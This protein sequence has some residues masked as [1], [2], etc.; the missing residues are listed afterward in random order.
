MVFL[1]RCNPLAI[2]VLSL[3]AIIYGNTAGSSWGRHSY[4]LTTFDP[5][6]NLD[7][8][9][10]A[11]RAS[12]LGVPIVALCLSADPNQQQCI[13]DSAILTSECQHDIPNTGGIYISIPLRFL[14]T[15]PLVIDDGTPRIVP[16]SSTLCLVHTGV[17][18]DGRALS[19]IA[20]KLVLDHKY[21]YGE[22]MGVQDLLSGL[23]SKMQEMTMKGGSRPYGCALLVCCLDESGRNAM[24][25][26]DPSGAVVL[27]SSSR[28]QVSDS[29]V[30]LRRSV[31]LMGNWESVK[32]K[33]ELIEQHL[34]K[35]VI[36]N[37]EQIQQLLMDAARQTFIDTSDDENA[38]KE[39]PILLAS[40]TRQ[41][42][43]SI[44]RIT[45]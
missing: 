35:Q 5:S 13:E 40:F 2:I 18:A 24:Y 42:G 31:T 9:V 29:G 39:T 3:P 27:M 4:S 25:R 6:G 33:R 32:Q 44:Q 1:Q 7:Q 20:I 37:E 21:L 45:T 38:T 16:L 15:S 43:M 34:E 26:V 12:T 11:I 17:G 10:R 8:V 22:E 36:N 30:G 19:D 41:S 14:S 23:S 28:E